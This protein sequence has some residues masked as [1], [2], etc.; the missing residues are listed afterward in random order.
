MNDLFL[1]NLIKSNNYDDFEKEIEMNPQIKHEVF[2]LSNKRYIDNPKKLESYYNFLNKKNIKYS[3]IDGLG[4]DRLSKKLNF[5]TALT[6]FFLH[7]GV[8][9]LIFLNLVSTNIWV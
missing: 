1:R 6:I 5:E 3:I 9:L 7:W 4:E 2:D 8:K